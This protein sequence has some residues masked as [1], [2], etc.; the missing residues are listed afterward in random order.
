M[1]NELDGVRMLLGHDNRVRGAAPAADIRAE[2]HAWSQW[3]EARKINPEA[4]G[5]QSRVGQ[6]ELCTPRQRPIQLS[7]QSVAVLNMEKLG[8]FESREQVSR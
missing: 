1:E 2:Q 7:P 8:I 5:C 6:A 3:A 4:H